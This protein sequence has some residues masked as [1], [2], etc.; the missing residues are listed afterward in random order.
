MHWRELGYEHRNWVIVSF[1]YTW[2]IAWPV[3]NYVNLQIVDNSVLVF[4]TDMNFIK[5]HYFSFI[6]DNRNF[7]WCFYHLPW[8]TVYRVVISGF[9]T[10]SL[11]WYV[12]N[13]WC[14]NSFILSVEMLFGPREMILWWWSNLNVRWF[15]IFIKRKK[16]KKSII[17]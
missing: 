16:T 3:L 11:L 14:E 15:I 13:T 17:L 8:K 7:T 10:S 6:F 1:P 12:E 5:T 9:C 2:L 4:L